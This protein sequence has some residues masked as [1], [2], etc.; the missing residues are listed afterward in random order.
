[1]HMFGRP[2]AGVPE[3]IVKWHLSMSCVD[4]TGGLTNDPPGQV[5]LVVGKLPILPQQRMLNG[6]CSN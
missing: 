6:L 5:E 2:S 4:D 1:M 3:D